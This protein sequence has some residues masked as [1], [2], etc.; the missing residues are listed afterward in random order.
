MGVVRGFAAS[1]ARFP[2][3][4]P[5]RRGVGSKWEGASLSL[6]WPGPRSGPGSPEPFRSLGPTPFLPSPPS[7]VIGP[8]EHTSRHRDF[9]PRRTDRHRRC[10]RWPPRVRSRPVVPPARRTV[11]WWMGGFS[12]RPQP[13]ARWSG[14][15]RPEVPEPLEGTATS[16]V[17]VGE[18][19][20]LEDECRAREPTGRSRPVSH[21][22]SPVPSLRFVVSLVSFRLVL[23]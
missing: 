16:A 7:S 13:A 14:V 5:R 9:P 22:P 1:L 21:F 10:R 12:V 6:R 19:S 11:G 23:Q 18:W 8:S 4:V 2:E 15:F 17:R 20:A 3:G